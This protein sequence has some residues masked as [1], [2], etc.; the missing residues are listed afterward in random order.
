VADL[1]AADRF[2]AGETTILAAIDALQRRGFAGVAANLLELGRQ[3]VAGDYLQPAAIFDRHFRVQSAINDPNDYAGPG[4][5]YRPSAERLSE[6]DALRQVRSPRE[7]IA[8]RIGAPLPGLAELGPARPGAGREVVVAVGPAFGTALTQTIGHLRHEDVLAAILTGVAREGL[9]A[10]V[11]KVFHSSDLA[12][13][14]H[15]GAALSGSGVAIGI[16]SRGTTIIQRRGL[17]RLNNL[18]L[19]P[20]S[21]SLTLA[22]YEAIGRNAA[23]YARGEP[24]APVPVQVDNWARLRLI[25]T[26]T[27]LHRRETEQIRDKPPS[28]LRFDWEPDV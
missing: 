23:R 12:A 24:V 19:F 15:A 22:T 10:R 9:T 25:V 26:T 11:V 27:L 4:T 7:F 2:L 28:E 20:Q 1:A 8:D 14:G 5:G 16:Q 3:R 6:I 13:I 18:E 21:P 17:A